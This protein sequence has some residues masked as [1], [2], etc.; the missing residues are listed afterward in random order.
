MRII[1]APFRQNTNFDENGGQEG[2]QMTTEKIKPA[3][4]QGSAY[5]RYEEIIRSLLAQ[6][7]RR[8]CR[9]SNRQIAL[10][11]WS[12][13][14]DHQIN[15]KSGRQVK[16][17]DELYRALMAIPCKGRY[18]FAENS[19]L[20]FS[21]PDGRSGGVHLRGRYVHLWEKIRRTIPKI[22]IEFQ[23]D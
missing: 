17:T 1:V 16:I 7:I 3:D 14:G 9:L 19:I 23:S 2:K 11:A 6:Q 21:A 4:E 5:S 8:E 12:Q 15:T 20:P 18:V 13:I 22:R 10:L